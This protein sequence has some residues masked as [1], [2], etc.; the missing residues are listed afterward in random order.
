MVHTFG[1]IRTVWG[2][3]LVLLAL[4]IL[5]GQIGIA[6]GA[7]RSSA[8]GAT[9]FG[10]SYG[11]R[12]VWMSSS[13]LNQ[14]LDD[15]VAVGV[16]WIR[17]DL[18]WKDIQQYSSTQYS[19]T[20]FDR[21]VAA[22]NSRHLT[23]LPVV[24]Y[25]PGWARPAGCTTEKCQPADPKQYAGFARAAVSRYASKG[26]HTWELWN[27]ENAAHYFAPT[28]SVSAYVGLVR[29][30]A[31]A[32]KGTDPGATVISGG[33]APE[34]TGNG[35]INQLDW[36]T[37][38]CNQGG[39]RFVDAI[40]FHPYSS[41]V[42]PGYVAKWNAWQQIS[43]T[44]TSFQSILSSCGYPN[45]KVW[46][47]EYGAPTQG[48]G[49]MGTSANNYG[50]GSGQKADHVSEAGQAQMATDS[51][52]L[53]KSSSTMGALFWY[54]NTDTSGAAPL[55]AYGLRRLDG[56]AKPAWGSLKQALVSP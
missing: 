4:A 3:T 29:A 30:A 1:R 18:S 19:W 46:A 53:A 17:L 26:I 31:P 33:L 25:T 28:A 38:F 8:N 49:L 9:R 51:V 32:I 44:P 36:L 42:P 21:V 35:N 22:A 11:D 5:S 43:N 55:S 56:S 14:T 10:V 7:T 39:T 15:A 13:V 52:H 41:P 20:N 50:I 24:A 12:L 48:P 37:A 54:T 34:P 40:G 47:T 23:L 16:G 6:S 45:M 2:S 27:E